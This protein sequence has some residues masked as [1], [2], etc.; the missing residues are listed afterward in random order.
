MSAALLVVDLQTNLLAVMP[1]REQLLKRASLA[2]SAS[3]LFALP[4]YVT[5]QVPEK[6]GPTDPALAELLAGQAKVFPKT[7][8]SALRAPGLLE[9][10]REANIRHLLVTGIETP[11]CVYQTALDARREGFD[12]TLL[13]DAIGQRREADADAC[14]RFLSSR[15]DVSLLPVETVFYSILGD[16]THPAFRDFTKLVKQAQAEPAQGKG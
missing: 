7:A 6:L 1:G 3:R 10:L 15:A 2:I 8:F 4:V 5:E 13:S 12:V 9:S 14:L 11:V 16:A